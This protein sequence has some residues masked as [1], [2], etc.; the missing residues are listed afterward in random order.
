V[1]SC[2]RWKNESFLLWPRAGCR[3]R[4]SFTLGYGRARATR[5]VSLFVIRNCN[6]QC[7]LCPFT[8]P[9][10]Q[11]ASIGHET[12]PSMKVMRC[13]MR[14]LLLYERQSTSDAAATGAPVE[15]RLSEQA[16]L[17]L[18]CND[19]TVRLAA[20]WAG[21]GGPNPLLSTEHAFS[22]ASAAADMRRSLT[23][24]PAFTVIADG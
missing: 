6:V 4:C 7:F 16:P 20:Q 21:P 23:V 24:E 1:A 10:A 13:E 18:C 15:R 17:Q 19:V 2:H 14:L 9:F 22:R 12:L 11:K 3:C 8:D 5:C